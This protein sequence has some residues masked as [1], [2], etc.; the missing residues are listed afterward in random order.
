MGGFDTRLEYTWKLET[1]GKIRFSSA[2]T[3]YDHYDIQIAQGAPFTPTAGL[4]TGL[5]GTIPRWRMYNTIG[6]EQDGWSV[7]VGQTYY[8]STIDTTW[9]PSWEP[10]YHQEIPAYITYDASVGY[11]WSA[12]W[13]RLKS[14]KVTF[15]V[16]NIGDVMPTKSA[17]FDSLSNADITEF[18]PIG[19]L[20]YVTLAMKF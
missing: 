6:W 15:G 2:G 13:K 12:G 4:V 8:S 19:R 9:D 17:T 10:D 5:N 3:Y 16:N 14:A 1:G 11:E 7:N 18:S 20:Y